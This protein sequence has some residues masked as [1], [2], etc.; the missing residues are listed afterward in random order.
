MGADVVAWLERLVAHPTV[1]DRPLLACAADI[2]E[3]CEALGFRIERFVD[4]LDPGKCTVLASIGPEGTDGL[5]LSGHMD[6]VPVVGQ[7]WTTDP[8]RLT[9]RDDTLVGRGSADM[10]GFIA[11]TLVALERIA[12]AEY[13]RELVLVWTHDEEIGCKG[14]AAFVEALGEVHRPFPKAT[15]IGE[16]T[17]FQVLRMHPGHVA[18]EVEVDGLAAHSSRPDLGLNAIEGAAEVVRIVSELAAQLALEPADLPELERPVVAVNTAT[19]H[20]G[21]A[22][23]IVPDRCVLQLGYRP[24]PGQGSTEVFERLQARIATSDIA[25]RT[26]ARVL[27]VTPA[28]L[29]PKGTHLE[30]TLC[31]HS[32]HPHVGAATFATDGGNLARLGMQPLVFGP[33]DINVAHKADEFVPVGELHHAVDVIE[34]VVRTHCT[35]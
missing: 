23:N 9:R 6:V 28:M 33:G 29:T 19:I 22:I 34:A 12:A 24:L 25:D 31:S 18:V 20:G 27:R 35:G 2:A 5:V 7:P 14:S 17:S 4:P 8:F 16:P 26:R 30:H 15:L 21:A 10:K 3:R 1:S 32:P 11:A 13:T